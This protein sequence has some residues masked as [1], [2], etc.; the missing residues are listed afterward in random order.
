M[1]LRSRQQRPNRRA[2][3]QRENIASFHQPSPLKPLPYHA[4][5]CIVHNGKLGPPMSALGQK[6]T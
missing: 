2:D 6:Q 3:N 1:L 5:G 4:K